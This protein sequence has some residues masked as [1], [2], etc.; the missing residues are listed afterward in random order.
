MGRETNNGERKMRW[1][2][3][4]R[5]M[6]GRFRRRIKVDFVTL[7]IFFVFVLFLISLSRK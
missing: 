6:L 4:E 7:F 1:R 3:R 5:E 2:S